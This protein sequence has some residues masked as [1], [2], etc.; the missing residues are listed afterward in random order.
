MSGIA[1]ADASLPAYASNGGG[2]GV[3]HRC[4]L[5]R[6]ASQP[7]YDGIAPLLRTYL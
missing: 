7:Q 3:A 1:G 2:G 5:E 6:L 4:L